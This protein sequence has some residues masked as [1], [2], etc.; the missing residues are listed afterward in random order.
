MQQ[1]SISFVTEPALH[2]II[3]R[4]HTIQSNSNELSTGNA[5]NPTPKDKH[6]M[7]INIYM[8]DNNRTNGIDE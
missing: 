4:K 7:L 2:S 3:K 8:R 1:R 5:L 6:T